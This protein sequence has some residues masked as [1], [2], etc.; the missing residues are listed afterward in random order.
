M[1]GKPYG[2]VEHLPAR[3]IDRTVA[4]NPLDQ[5]AKPFDP[6]FKDQRF[7][8][9]EP[10]GPGLG[11]HERLQHHPAF[12]DETVAAPGQVTVAH[13][14]E[15]GNPRIRRIL[16]PDQPRRALG[17]HD[18]RVITTMSLTIRPTEMS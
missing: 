4:I 5:R 12:G 16:D 15:L 1:H 3:D 7:L 6:V 2:S 13:R 11:I 14:G 18:Q 8:E 10:P 9:H 17:M